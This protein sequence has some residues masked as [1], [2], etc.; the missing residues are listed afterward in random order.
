MNSNNK[1]EILKVHQ[2]LS[3]PNLVIPDYQRP[4]KWT[5]KH[6]QPLLQDIDIYN[7]ATAYRLGSIVFHKGQAA[8]KLDKLNIVDGQQRTLTLVLAANAII[9]KRLA[10][11]KRCIDSSAS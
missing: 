2:L 6:I 5:I 10:G 3:L 7:S 8:E 11:L 4:Y 1:P 9:D